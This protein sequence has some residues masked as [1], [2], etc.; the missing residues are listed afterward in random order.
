M[1]PLFSQ[2]QF[3]QTPQN[4]T[5]FGNMANMMNQFNQ[6]RNTFRG[7]PQQIVMNMLS[8]GQMSQQQF[9]QLKNMADQFQKMMH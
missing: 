7:N 6:F 5:P 3:N 1:N 9:N 4:N 2:Q 8:N